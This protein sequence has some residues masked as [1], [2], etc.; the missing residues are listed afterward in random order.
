MINFLYCDMRQ[1]YIL[2]TNQ[3]NAIQKNQPNTILDLKIKV[4]FIPMPIKQL[5][6]NFPLERLP[7]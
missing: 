7:K 3:S 6:N 4:P 1:L 2:S 5:L